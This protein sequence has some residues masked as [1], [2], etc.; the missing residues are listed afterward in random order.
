[1]EC[2]RRISDNWYLASGGHHT[3]QPGLAIVLD[4]ED[5]PRWLKEWG[6]HKAVLLQ[7]AQEII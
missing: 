4:A 5:V 7:N 1:M 6:D 3:S 2:L